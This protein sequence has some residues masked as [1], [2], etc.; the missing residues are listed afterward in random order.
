MGVEVEEGVTAEVEVAEGVGVEV[1]EGVTAEVEVAEVDVDVAAGLVDRE[2][3]GVEGVTAEGEGVTAGVA[4]EGEE[5][6][7]EDF[8][9]VPTLVGVLR[10]VGVIGVLQ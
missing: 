2:R 9:K 4:A 6:T 10:R 1:E 3:V 8:R 7:A 5:V